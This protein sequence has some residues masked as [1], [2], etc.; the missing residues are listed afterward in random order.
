MIRA[1]LQRTLSSI[2]RIGSEPNDDDDI[3]LQ[4]SLL[5]VCAFPF[6]FAG[7]AWG[8]MYFFFN[9]PLATATWWLLACHVVAPIM[10]RHWSAWHWKCAIILLPIRFATVIS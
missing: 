5:V 6:M 10:P 7:L 1:M 3:R 4:K 2:T 9:E 8:L